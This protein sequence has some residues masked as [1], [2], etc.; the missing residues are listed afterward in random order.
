MSTTPSPQ[1]STP[2]SRY[3]MTNPV[4]LRDLTP[5]GAWHPL[6]ASEHVVQFYE[7]DAF[8]L[9]VLSDFI[10]AGLAAGD[11]C[12]VV[13]TPAH[14]AGLDDRL[15]TAGLDLAAARAS[16]Q[17]V[18][19][20]A[21]DTL[22]TF[23]DAGVPVPD[24]FAQVLGQLVARAA[25]GRSQ[26]RIFGEM[27][28]LLWA[29]GQHEAALLLEA[30][31]N[32]LHTQHA[33]VLCC[34]YPIQGFGGE[35]LAQGLKAVCATHGRVIPTES[36][37]TLATADDRLRA[38]SVLQQQAHSLASEIA[39]RQA[40]EADLRRAKRDLEVQVADLRRLH[41]L[42]VNLT[43]TLD[44]ATVLREVLQAA[45]L[46]HET[47]L[48]LVSLC[49]PAGAGL[50]LQASRGFDAAFVQEVAWVPLGGGACGT[51]YAERRR[52]VV[53]DVDT[54]PIFVPYRAATRRAGFQA[55]H[56]TPLIS[57]VGT[58][59]GVLS[60]HFRQP[61]RPSERE[62]QLMDLYA[63]VA[64]DALENARLYQ[65]A[66]DAIQVRDQFLAMAAHELK[67]PL[68]VL[69]GNAQLLQRRMER[70]GTATG[71]IAKAV[72]VIVAQAKR[73]NAMLVPLLDVSRIERGQFSLER[74]PL[75]LGALVR[76]V[77]EE[78]QPTCVTHQLD[79]QTPRDPVI[80][81]GD[82][83]R[84]EH[85]VQ[86]LVTNAIKYSPAGGPIIVRVEHDAQQVRLLVTDRGIGIPQQEQPRLF[87]RFY[88]ASNAEQQQMSGMGLGLYVVKEI[89]TLHGGTVDVESDEH[90]GSTFR[91]CFPLRGA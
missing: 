67:T 35:A 72:G 71:A 79:C 28:A 34:A 48:G 9:Q 14:R 83:V 68:T 1:R 20:D 90:T 55:V 36:Y 21:A 84:L 7:T 86:H 61:Y 45:L 42:S 85:V 58:V 60:V 27:V 24:R 54:D 51:C 47:D 65:A 88:R 70:E 80:L 87:R 44:R 8:L 38:I 40:V 64:V 82:A 66:Q 6:H 37:T 32:D 73:L 52:V 76:R 18:V 49:D 16:G 25:T 19:L 57:R 3:P 5:Q 69:F 29:E 2:E 53:E 12:L 17:Y 77:V 56:S 33:F 39:E 59:I 63:Q 31:W 43:R 4:P 22:A 89:V 30:L 74:A 13:A 46:V 91:V 23:M 75:D 81:D 62:M 41:A 50:T 78:I 10:S 15:L 11:A 26:V